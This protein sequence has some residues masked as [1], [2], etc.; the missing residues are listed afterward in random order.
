MAK[1][2]VEYAKE[3]PA[4]RGAICW[5][6]GIPEAEE[7]NSGLRSGLYPTQIREWL[8][9][10]CGYDVNVCTVAKIHMH[11]QKGHHEKKSA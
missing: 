11:K 3:N 4:K 2:L 1:S 7:V 10:E 9:N 8:V 5:A 6:C